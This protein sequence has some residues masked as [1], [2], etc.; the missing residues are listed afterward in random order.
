MIIYLLFQ[1]IFERTG[2]R[3]VSATNNQVRLQSNIYRYINSSVIYCFRLQHLFRP[4]LEFKILTK[5][6]Y[7]FS[8]KILGY[9]FKKLD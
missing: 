1:I 6:L 5:L 7:V 3:K 9:Y 4:I 8:L 2:I